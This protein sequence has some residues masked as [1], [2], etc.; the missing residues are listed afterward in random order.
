MSFATNVGW[1]GRRT[2]IRALRVVYLLAMV[3]MMMKTMM[4]TQY[5]LVKRICVNA[6]M[7]MMVFVGVTGKTLLI[8]NLMCKFLLFFKSFDSLIY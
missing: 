8:I 5:I 7:M 6:I 3:I 1:S 4:M 2:K